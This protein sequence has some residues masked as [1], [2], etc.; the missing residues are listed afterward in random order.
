MAAVMLSSFDSLPIPLTPL[1]GREP[2][3]EAIHALLLQRD[4]RLLTLTGPGGVGKTRLALQIAANLAN[5]FEDGVIHVSLAPIRDPTLVLPAIAQASGLLETGGATLHERLVAILGPRHTLLLL[6]NVEQVLESVPSVT[7]LLTA[8]PR[9]SVLATSRIPLRA[10]GE[11]VFDVPP[12]A[13]PG[14]TAS[15][16]E[17]ATAPEAAVRLFVTR[18]QAARRD[19]ALRVDNAEVV[20]AICRRVDGLPLA[21]ELAAAQ[22]RALPLPALLT[23]LEQRLPVLTGGPRD[24]PERQQAMR[25]AIAWSYDLLSAWEQ[26]LFRRLAVFVG[27]FDLAA[28]EAVIST[29]GDS[30][31][32]VADGI[33]AL[34]DA[35]LLRPDEQPDG[36]PRFVML[37]TIREYGAELLAASG[38]EA[39]L[40]DA[41][42][43]WCLRL[44][45]EAE[46]HW[47]A[48]TRRLWASRLE[49]DY[50]NLR[51]AL[52]WFEQRSIE[53]GLRLAR[54]LHWFWW[55]QAHAAEGRAWLERALSREEPIEPRVRSGAL[56]AAGALAAI[57]EDVDR[58]TALLAEGETIAKAIGDRDGMITALSWRAVVAEVQ[59][60]LAAV[61]ALTEAELVL[62]RESGDPSMIALA[63]LNTAEA[64]Y[65]AGDASGAATRWEASLPLARANGATFVL[66]LGLPVLA[67]VRLAE[68]E[69]DQALAMCQEAL[70]LSEDFGPATAANALTGFAGVA[71]ARGEPI[72][73]ARLLG[74]VQ[75]VS[76]R[77]G[78]RRA[79]ALGQ[80]QRVVAAVR[81]RLDEPAFA[82]AW[83]AGRELSFPEATAEALAM[84][85]SVGVGASHPS[86]PAPANP[87]GL[88]VR[89]RDILRLVVAGKSN[90]EIGALLFISH[91]TAATHLRN[92]YD[93]LGVSGRAEAI[94]VAIRRELV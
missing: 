22:V 51:A 64:A 37:E 1:M 72:R 56:V 19:F 93:K 63:L 32:S 62:A 91:R 83:K 74:A 80:H 3:V 34:V 4:V 27:G 10:S 75:T 86:L 48:A 9:L 47:L 17:L 20:A 33:F 23:R 57:H 8:C 77:L 88:T 24:A 76:E 52:T 39:T 73:A 16:I 50:A 44:A 21:V 79:P 70:L 28:A 41:H 61:V 81:A 15:P 78:W 6:D 65:N 49:I 71:A 45:E 12:L 55:T 13:L 36:T 69:A 59:G 38:E 67:E 85:A 92:I 30:G 43:A 31:N 94:S 90:P 29:V 58:A 54:T 18:A 5:E 46:Q 40:R 87:A 2:E 14:S 7:R 35:S 60:D 89:E 26:Q 82:A 84:G 66:A 25:D 68:G 11:H 53:A 42:A